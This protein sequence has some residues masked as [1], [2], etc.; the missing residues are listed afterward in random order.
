MGHVD[1]GAAGQV[2]VIGGGGEGD[3]VGV[4]A[5][6]CGHACL[7]VR[8]EMVMVIA[9]KNLASVH[10]SPTSSYRLPVPIP[11]PTTIK[12]II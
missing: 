10:R 1:E 9:S 2:F 5:C 11:A 12:R 4:G 7:L 6:A 3:G 8:C